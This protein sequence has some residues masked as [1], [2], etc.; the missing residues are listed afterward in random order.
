MH[1]HCTVLNPLMAPAAVPSAAEEPR[2]SLV[3]IWEKTRLKCEEVG[4]VVGRFAAQQPFT[5]ESLVVFVDVI[6][7]VRGTSRT[8][9]GAVWPLQRISTLMATLKGELVVYP[10]CGTDY[11]V[12]CVGVLTQPNSPDYRLDTNQLPVPPV[13][14]GETQIDSNMWTPPLNASPPGQQV[15]SIE[16]TEPRAPSHILRDLSEFGTLAIITSFDVPQAHRQGAK[17]SMAVQ[18]PGVMPQQHKR[19][20]Y[21]VPAKMCMPRMTELF[22]QLKEKDE[23][24]VGGTVG[25]VLSAYAVQIKLKYEDPRPSLAKACRCGRPRLGRLAS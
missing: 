10:F 21:I 1:R 19:I 11:N 5:Q 9:D 14:V 15:N 8:L 3:E 20:A 7:R 17:L 6:K 25:A 13:Q 12:T 2:P 22:L 23:V 24:F 4:A 18:A 16:L